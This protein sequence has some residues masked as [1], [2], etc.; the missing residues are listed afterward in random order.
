MT[1]AV[2]ACYKLI[3]ALL[4]MHCLYGV[5]GSGGSGGGTS[6]RSHTSSAANKQA[7]SKSAAASN[8]ATSTAATGAAAGTTAAPTSGKGTTATRTRS[9]STSASSGSSN[10]APAAAVA[11]AT[12]AA[13]TAAPAPAPA[14]AAAAPA[15]AA[16]KAAAAAAPPA[17]KTAHSQQQQ[18][19][20]QQQPNSDLDVLHQ[21]RQALLAQR[22]VKVALQDIIDTC[23][24]PAA[25]KAY[26]KQCLRA[27]TDTA[28]STAVD[29]SDS[30]ST[31]TPVSVLEQ[32]LQSLEQLRSAV[33]AAA[34]SADTK[35]QW[36]ARLLNYGAA[37]VQRSRNEKQLPA[38]TVS[39]QRVAGEAVVSVQLRIVDYVNSL[40]AGSVRKCMPEK[41]KRCVLHGFSVQLTA[42]ATDST[43]TTAA[44]TGTAA[45]AG[46]DAVTEAA[47]CYPAELAMQGQLVQIVEVVG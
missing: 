22:A 40:P 37:A 15:P 13:K 24:A 3:S 28:C 12:A 9:G 19:Q 6:L 44:A 42:A 2:Y 10:S 5:D 39:E 23:S 21:Q 45:A 27:L 8:T 29:I 36:L 43:A 26:W 1:G 47:R 35:D 41:W 14:A 46:A 32:Q 31:D 30:S 11:K 20:E 33:A 34:V 16:A 38:L 4:C 17:A 7:S 25:A 18:Q